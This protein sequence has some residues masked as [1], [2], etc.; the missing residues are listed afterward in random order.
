MGQ[1]IF[2]PL[3]FPPSIEGRVKVL[4]MSTDVSTSM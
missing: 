1:C 2:F 4:V 3:F